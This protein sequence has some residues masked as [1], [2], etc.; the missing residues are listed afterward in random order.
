MAASL[1]ERP[2]PGAFV[3]G[4]RHA[5]LAA[6]RL[7]EIRLLDGPNV[8]RLE[9]TVK[10]EVGVGRRRTWFGQRLPGTHARVRLGAPV[11]RTAAP[12]PVADLAAWVAR[13]HHLS[14]ADAWLAAEGRASSRGARIPAHIHRTSEPGIWVVAYPWRE[15]GRARAIAEAALRLVELDLDPH[16]TRPATRRTSGRA[17]R[18]RTL[19]R[20]IRAIQHAETGPPAWIRDTQRQVP[21]ISIS[22]T[23][24]KTTTTRMISHILR[25][26]GRHVGTTT[27]DGVLFDEGLV[28]AGDLTGP[29]GARLVL[30]DPRV[31]VA[32]LETA[33]GGLMLRGAGYESNDASVITN[34]SSDHMDLH[35]IHTLPELAEVKSVITRMTV[36]EGAVVLDADDKL[37]AAMARRVQ[38]PVWWCSMRP[39]STRI[40]RHLARGGRAYVLDGRIARGMRWRGPAPDR[41]G[42]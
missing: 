31:D 27:S 12:R 42:R 22:G 29:Y 10:V 39:R 3:A 21:T 11:P 36:R 7:V 25:R 17:G 8:Y 33:R 13:L 1:A 14:G 41:R 30:G 40:R 38:A 35:G 15:D 37:V 34:V 19:T 5:I 23:N 9:P 20:A 4:S 32:V 24:G 16:A 2:A 6:V 28:E 18:S 26:A